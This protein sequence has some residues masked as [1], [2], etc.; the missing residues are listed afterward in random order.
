MRNTRPWI[1]AMLAIACKSAPVGDT[2][3][4]LP[5]AVAPPVQLAAVENGLLPPV[6]ITGV[7]LRMTVTQRLAHHGVPAIGVAVIDH[8]AVH[9]ARTWGVLGRDPDHAAIAAD[10]ETRFHAASIRDRKSVV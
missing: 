5:P 6:T 9:W 10:A 8:G 4:I 2:T 7:D 1:A 3:P